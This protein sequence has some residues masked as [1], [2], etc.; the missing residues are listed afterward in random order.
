ML[1]PVYLKEFKR[2][3]PE[4]RV[5]VRIGSGRERIRWLRAHEVDL[6]LVAVDVPPPDLEFRPILSSDFVFITPEDHPLAGRESVD[7]AEVAAYPAVTHTHSHYVGQTMDILMRVHGEVPNTVLEVDGW[8][9][10]KLHVA[11]GVGIAAVP[12]ICVSEHDRIWSI[13]ASRYFPSRL[14]GV[15]A[16]RDEPLSLAAQWL[17][18]LVEEHHPVAP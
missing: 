11:A 9:V 16:R 12:D 10:I 5:N 14:Y 1:L 17:M 18:R 3:H 7:I 4:I 13:P 6:V 8:N 2:R 15:L